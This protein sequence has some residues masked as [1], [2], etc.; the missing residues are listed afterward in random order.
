MVLLLLLLH[1]LPMT[2]MR[3]GTQSQ[4][5]ARAQGDAMP[6]KKRE[7]RPHSVSSFGRSGFVL[8]SRETH[9]QQVVL[10]HLQQQPST[11]AYQ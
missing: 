9:E 6:K 8:G 10:M 5:Q 3:R 7:Q 11:R 1:L 4:E 2:K